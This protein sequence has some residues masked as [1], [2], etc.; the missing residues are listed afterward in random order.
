[1]NATPAVSQ[2]HATNAG[3]CLCG[4]GETPAAKSNYRPGHDARHVSI[5]LQD[6][7]NAAADEGHKKHINVSDARGALAAL[8]SPELKAK[9]SGAIARFNAGRPAKVQPSPARADATAE[10]V[11]VEA[12]PHMVQPATE[13]QIVGLDSVKVGRWEYPGRQYAD[14]TQTRN[15]QRD[16]SGE[17]VQA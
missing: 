1:M 9:L 8:P 14:G 2:A 16:G 4:C 13:P 7:K 11:E 10:Q 6:L 5:L 17:W 15:T 12:D 3:Q